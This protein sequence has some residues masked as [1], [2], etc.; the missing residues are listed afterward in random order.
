MDESS[1]GTP[2][3]GTTSGTTTSGVA[4]SSASTGSVHDG[5]VPGVY[6]C[7]S[8]DLVCLPSSELCVPC[9]PLGEA[10]V[11]GYC[12][13]GAVVSEDGSTCLPDE[14][15]GCRPA[16]GV[17]GY[18]G[19]TIGCCD[20]MACNPETD[21]CEPLQSC[22]DYVTDNIDFDLCP[23]AGETTAG[24]VVEKEQPAVLEQA[25][26][27]TALNTEGDVERIELDCEGTP[28]T[29]A[30]HSTSPHVVAPVAVDDVITLSWAE[31]RAAPGPQPSFTLRDSEGVL[32][33][34][35]VDHHA[36]NDELPVDIS[37][38]EVDPHEA[39]CSVEDAG[40]AGCGDGE[41]IVSRRMNVF[42]YV[43]GNYRAQLGDGSAEQFGASGRTYD[44][45]LEEATQIVCSDE[46]CAVDDSGPYD[47]LRM[48]IVARS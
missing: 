25:C 17:C 10:P 6:S 33:V 38:I 39:I 40:G 28:R 26:G 23:D 45:L 48:L 37:P 34:A 27:V 47:H 11:D 24:T 21:L 16:G 32:L 46:S 31:F 35:W 41:A 44:V 22:L 5:C 15:E 42:F 20:G 36:T 2:E 4:D 13:S 19:V 12:C 18:S 9:G 8:D 43:N 3:P 30:Y 7:P 1:S 14:G 29:V